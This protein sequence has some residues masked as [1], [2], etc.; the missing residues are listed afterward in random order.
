MINVCIDQACGT[1]KYNA[2]SVQ[3]AS[4]LTATVTATTGTGGLDVDLVYAKGALLADGNVVG[5][6][7][8]DDAV[9]VDA[10]SDPV[11]YGATCSCKTLELA[12]TLAPRM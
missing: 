3:L 4:V 9:R 1:G 12:L 6:D 2:T 8:Y 7:V 5:L 10:V 11:T